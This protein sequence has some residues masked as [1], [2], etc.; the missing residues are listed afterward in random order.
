[1]TNSGGRP[2]TNGNGSA[3]PA[4]IRN[5]PDPQRRGRPRSTGGRHCDRCGNDVAK[6]RVRWPD[7][8]VCGACFTAATHR[9]GIC[10]ICGVHRMLPGRFQLGQ[11]I[12]RDCAGISTN[13]S[14]ARCGREAERIHGG[15]CARCVLND[16]LEHLLQPGDDRPLQKLI[17]A[18]VAVERPESLITYTRGARARELLTRI[19][20][21]ELALTHDAFDA[22]PRSTAAEHL[23]ALLTHHG[24]LPNRGSDPV[25]RFK[26]WLAERLDTLPDDGARSSIE[27]FAT[28]RHLRRIREREQDD[29]RNLTTVTH[30]AKQEITEA[31]KFLAWLRSTYDTGPN[32]VQ[33]AHVDEYL[34]AGSTTR[35]HIRNYLHWLEPNRTRRFRKVDAPYRVA[36]S[37]PIVTQE[38]RVQMV[39]NCL[40]FDQV[41]LSTRIAG[42]ILLLWAQPLN[43]IVMLR[44]RDVDIRVDGLYLN[45]GAVPS[46]VPPELAATFGDYFAH[47]SNQRTGNT[48]TE[49]LFPGTRA[50]RHLHEN[51]LSDRLRILGIDAQ[52]ARNATLQDLTHE[53]DARSLIDL[54]G[55]SGKVITLH[56]AR[57][58]APRSDYIALR[59]KPN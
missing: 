13:L 33:Q 27:Q 48:G 14:C 44:Q 7:G 3:R 56:A 39:R 42:L 23:R 29:W 36:N 15:H 37:T 53:V 35:R 18:L 59:R 9:Y 20:C 22:L 32:G 38:Q 6:I 12:C 26:T 24:V 40:E 31:G 16:E 17:I 49:W 58:G 19:G 10:A 50:G 41:V 52:R 46:I 11:P 47:P 54:L 55:Y 5:L 2:A 21:R 45:F 25:A 1:M 43:R 57:A 51:T 4:T 30:A 34:V 8:S 28:W